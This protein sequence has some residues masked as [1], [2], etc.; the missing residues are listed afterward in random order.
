MELLL[1]L[2]KHPKYPLPDGVANVQNCGSSKCRC[3]STMAYDKGALGCH[4]GAIGGR[5]RLDV[6]ACFFRPRKFGTRFPV[7]YGTIY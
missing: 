4:H 3:L 1:L 5:N 6:L 7:R 2:L